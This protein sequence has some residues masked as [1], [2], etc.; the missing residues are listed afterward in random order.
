MCYPS[1]CY[2]SS[3]PCNFPVLT[4]SPA[5]TMETC[6]DDRSSTAKDSD[7]ESVS[8]DEKETLLNSGPMC[9]STPSKMISRSRLYPLLA[10][11]MAIGNVILGALLVI[12]FQTGHHTTMPSPAMPHNHNHEQKATPVPIG[13]LP[14]VDSHPDW[15]P[16]E[17]W[18]TE[19]FRLHQIYGE[20]PVGTAKEAWLSLIPSKR[21]FWNARFSHFLLTILSIQ[22]AKGLLPSKMTQRCLTCPAFAIQSTSNTHA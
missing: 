21:L 1:R 3:M 6:K 12:Q 10:A 5:I 20:E 2:Y 18:R 19:V 11:L 16:P 22:R 7:L 15:L 8:W 17:E 14:H 13:G 4:K 9:T